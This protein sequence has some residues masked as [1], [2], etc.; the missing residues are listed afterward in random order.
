MVG[1][2]ILGSNGPSSSPGRGHCVVFLGKTLKVAYFSIE[3]KMEHKNA[4]FNSSE[5]TS[6]LFFPSLFTVCLSLLLFYVKFE[7][8]NVNKWPK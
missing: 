7:Q 6:K 5:K 2:L 8:L 1:V 4:S 3:K